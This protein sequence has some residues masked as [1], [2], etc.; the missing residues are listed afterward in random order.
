MIR[1]D[2]GAER[3]DELAEDTRNSRSG[4]TA[5]GF[6]PSAR[7]LRFFAVGL[8]NTAFGYAIF[9]LVWRETLDATIAAAVSTVIGAL[10]NFL[11]IGRL[12]FGS[13]D[14]RFLGRFV[15]VYGLLFLVD[16]LALKA[17]E[18]YGAAAS[19]AQAALTPLLAALSYLLNRDFVFR[20]GG[21]GA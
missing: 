15:A 5:L 7:A 10:F 4:A 16:A 13:S 11:S 17:L 20:S 18:H 14:P 2:S 3:A 1:R 19:I 6:A 21:G 9:Y 8:V 12:V